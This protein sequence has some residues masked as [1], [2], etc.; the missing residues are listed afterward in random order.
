VVES[1]F[2]FRCY[3][4]PVDRTIRTR[5]SPDGYSG[6]ITDR[7][8]LENGSTL[9]CPA[10]STA[11]GRPSGVSR[12]TVDWDSGVTLRL[13]D[14]DAARVKRRATHNNRGAPSGTQ[15]TQ[16]PKPETAPTR[17]VDNGASRIHEFASRQHQR[18]RGARLPCHGGIQ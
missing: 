10:P 4:T 2:R 9:R 11:A 1:N 7:Y 5:S 8:V 17:I 13:F 3:R 15:A 12:L 6:L 18:C 14:L 16:L